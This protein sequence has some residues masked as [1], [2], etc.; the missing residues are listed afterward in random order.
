M[1][2]RPPRSTLFPY[3]TLFRSAPRPAPSRR[4]HGPGCT[5]TPPPTGR[6][7]GPPRCAGRCGPAP[8][9]QPA[10]SPP[11]GRQRLVRGPPPP[12]GAARTCATGPPSHALASLGG[13]SRRRR[14]RDEPGTRKPPFPE[15]LPR[16][17]AQLHIQTTPHPDDRVGP[18]P[19]ASDRRAAGGPAVGTADQRR[20]RTGLEVG[21]AALFQVIEHRLPGR[22]RQR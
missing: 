8:P 13:H 15:E 16:R 12:P 10:R 14:S 18:P 19:R 4:S 7:T 22:E 9:H 11:T 1:I 2:R 20:V 5:A 21:A 3:T 17:A 6:P